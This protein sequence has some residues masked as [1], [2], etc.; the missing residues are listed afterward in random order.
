[1]ITMYRKYEF[2]GETKEVG[3][4]TLRRIIAVKDFCDEEGN[5]FIYDGDVGGWIESE[6]NLSHEGYA[7]V[8]DEACVYENARVQENASVEG[9]AQM[10]GN[11]QAG[12][13]ALIR[14]YAMV[15]EN[16]RIEGGIVEDRAWVHGDARLNEHVK[17]Y[18][19]AD[20]WGNV[21][22][23]D[24]VSLSDHAQVN[25]S[26]TD[27]QLTLVLMGGASFRG[28]A[29][30]EKESDYVCVRPVGEYNWA[31]TAYRTKRGVIECSCGGF[32]GNIERVEKEIEKAYGKEA[33][34]K[35][36]KSIF[37]M[38]KIKLA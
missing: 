18:G 20:V 17:V 7:W 14:D 13:Y 36:F 35:E 26:R 8:A 9:F 19:D 12:G 30:V 21:G 11:A 28:Y 38:A 25:G 3:V 29:Y 1:V 34:E 27:G 23:Y 2:T 5:W 31:F 6:E 32:S 16:A 24:I 22:L 4:H 10:F 33:Y 37:E 15:Y